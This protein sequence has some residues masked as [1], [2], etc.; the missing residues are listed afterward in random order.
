MG[1]ILKA[2]RLA[3]LAFIWLVNV[4]ALRLP[5]NVLRVGV[6]RLCGARVGAGTRVER[7]VKV[8]FPWR[9][10]IGAASTIN[11]GV[12][13]DCR[14]AAIHVGDL[15]DISSEAIVYTLTHDVHGL[16]FDVRSGAVELADS[17]WICARAIVLPGSVIGRGS[18]VAA[19]SVIKGHVSDHQL[20]Q[21]NPAV[22]KKD[23]PAGRGSARRK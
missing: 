1:G 16:E 9:L 20:W 5:G 10:R 12:Y 13:L 3:Y 4:V 17:V 8:D 6:L 11:P 22:F 18:V 19:N 14:G 7:G 2:R 21:G 15:V 23:L